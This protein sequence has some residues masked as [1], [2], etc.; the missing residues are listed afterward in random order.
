MALC[1]DGSGALTGTA[2]SMAGGMISSTHGSGGSSAAA[3]STSDATLF[4][5]TNLQARFVD[6]QDAL[7][8]TL[9][10]RLFAKAAAP[11]SMPTTAIPTGM[12]YLFKAPA[13]G[14]PISVKKDIP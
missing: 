10:R 12:R 6:S 11:I 1:S 7:S 2:R 9:A 8:L 5:A 4:H 14:I 3:G 13:K